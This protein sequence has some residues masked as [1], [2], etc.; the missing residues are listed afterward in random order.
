[1]EA[2][3]TVDQYLLISRPVIKRKYTLAHSTTY[4]LIALSQVTELSVV[5]ISQ[6]RLPAI[7]VKSAKFAGVL[8]YFILEGLLNFV[9]S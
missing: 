7:L 4:T 1:M 5:Q 8:E 6:T 2:Y 9:P 3:N